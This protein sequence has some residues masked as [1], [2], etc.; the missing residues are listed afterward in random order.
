VYR[1]SADLS[2]SPHLS[3]AKP[4]DP[5]VRDANGDGTI[6]E[7]DK[8]VLG[9]RQPDFIA[10]VTNTFSFKGI[11]LSFMVQASYGG[12]IVNQQW[13][14]CGVWNGGRNL[15]AN[16]ANYWKSPGNPGDGVHFRPTIDDDKVAFQGEFSNLWVEDA[17]FLRLKNIRLSYALPQK[18][19]SHA[20][21]QSIKLYANIENALLFTKYSGYDPENTTYN[22]TT[23]SGTASTLTTV[24]MTA[25]SYNSITSRSD[26]PT[27]ALLGVDYGSYP[28]PRVISFGANIEF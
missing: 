13:R 1:D 18:W 28:V 9:N 3:T 11:E 16:A 22:A 24:G 5:K 15:Y 8:I 19:V 12:K 26:L 6:S 14:Y 17:S 25:D 2:N 23:Y 21:L 20:K 4:G 10:S 7:L 27:G